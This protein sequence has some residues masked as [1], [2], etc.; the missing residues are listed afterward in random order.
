VDDDAR[1]EFETRL[2]FQEDT[3]AKLNDA[4][5]DQQ[6]QI[7]VLRD[8][9]ARLV[10]LLERRADDTRATPGDERPPHY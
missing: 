9:I 10:D 1:I 2:L 6:R 8:T 7:D 5:V 3:I 4:L